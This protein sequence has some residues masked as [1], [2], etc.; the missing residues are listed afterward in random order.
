MEINKKDE[1]KR[2]LAKKTDEIIEEKSW[3]I[4]QKG[5]GK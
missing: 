1:T 5:I 3:Q 2:R 4:K